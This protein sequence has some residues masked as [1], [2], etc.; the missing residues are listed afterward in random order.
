M[1]EASFFPE[2]LGGMDLV[3]AATSD[4][5]LNGEIGRLC[6]EQGIPVNVCSRKEDCDFFFP[7]VI[8][9]GDLVIGINASGKDH[10][11]VKKTRQELRSFLN[12]NDFV[13]SLGAVLL[14]FGA[15]LLLGDPATRFHPICLMGNLFLTWRKKEGNGFRRRRQAREK[16]G[17]SARCR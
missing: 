13:W 1:K 4:A 3:L 17:S 6:R 2:A 16:P 11:L 9:K 12:M 10:R 7:S 8:Q 15:D 14:G 5:K